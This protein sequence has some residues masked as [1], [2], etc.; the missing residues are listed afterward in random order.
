[1]I[2]AEQLAQLKTMISNLEQAKGDADAKTQVSNQADTAAAQAAADAA[3]AKLDEAA[4]D[5]LVTGDL[6]ELVAFVD[7]LVTPPA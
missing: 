5:A 3:Q 2:T 6:Q 7:G 4:A 1:M